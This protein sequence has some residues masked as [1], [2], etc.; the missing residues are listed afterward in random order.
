[1]NE[2]ETPS[3]LLTR[4]R[5]RADDLSAENY[6]LRHSVRP[7]P[8][9][10]NY[11]IATVCICILALTGC[12]C[13]AILDGRALV[14]AQ[15]GVA[16]KEGAK[17]RDLADRHAKQIEQDIR[18]RLDA[19]LVRVDTLTN[20]A[21]T[22]L[23]GA[24]ADI[25]EIGDLFSSRVDAVKDSLIAEI[26]PVMANAAQITANA[27]SITA[28][29]DEASAILFRRDALPAQ[30]LGVTAAA[31]VTLGE[32]AQTMRTVR[33]AAPEISA[34]AIKVSNSVASIADSGAQEAKKFTAPQT[35]REKIM[36]WLQLVPRLAL[37]I[38]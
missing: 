20:K 18:L 36:L 12:L 10:K 19:V 13:L 30:L 3:D 11:L 9:M 2:V 22:Q 15:F 26:H 37:K 6:C 34:A 31:K 33:D 21:D 27:A 8:T 5:L 25:K 23:T 32:T 35:R 29:A 1:M 38:L 16:Q 7:R 28:H 17:T 4:L 24:R 14:K